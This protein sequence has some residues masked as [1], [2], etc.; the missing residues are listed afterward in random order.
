MTD[1]R[2]PA[3]WTDDVRRGT[4]RGARL[5]TRAELRELVAEHRMEISEV[6]AVGA[7]PRELMLDHEKKLRAYASNLSPDD[8]STFLRMYAEEMTAAAG[9]NEPDAR[10][11]AGPAGA[12]A[13]RTRATVPI[14]TLSVIVAVLVSLVL[15]RACA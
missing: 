14:I 2:L 12:A 11:L 1:P 7:N 13:W 3:R 9:T 5:P 6:T 10:L 8:A 15:F 4:R